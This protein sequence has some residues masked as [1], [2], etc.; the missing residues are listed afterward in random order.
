MVWDDVRYFLAVAREGSIRRAAASLGVNHSTVSRRIRQ[1]EQRYGARL[2]DPLPSG[3]SL[4]PTGED[5]LELAREIELD[6]SVLTGRLAGRDT[7]ISGSVRIAI[8]DN[9]VARLAPLLARMRAAYPAVQIQ[10]AVSNDVVN[11]SNR[12]AEIALRVSNLAPEPMVG[13]RLGTMAMALYA[14]RRYLARNRG[15][16]KLTSYDWIGWD[17]SW[18][19]E[20]TRW[21][22]QTIPQQNVACRVDSPAAMYEMTR[23]GVGVAHLLCYLGDVDA[24]LVRVVPEVSDF[25]AGLWL[26]THP[27]LKGTAR[28]RGVMEF[29]EQEFA[30]QIDLIEGRR[31]GP[32]RSRPVPDPH[33][34]IR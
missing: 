31:P 21:M 5:V 4:T 16:R 12:E 7:Q 19:N 24:D 26:L 34:P 28:V 29:I 14:S 25:S 9:F 1:L 17:E 30:K 8:G 20:H 18:S 6:M 15:V 33:L 13:K 32:A 2:F 3:F 22:K 10:L 23:A 11:L 27:D